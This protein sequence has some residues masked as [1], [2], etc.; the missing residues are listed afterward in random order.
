[1]ES[2]HCFHITVLN[3][4][5]HSLVK[6]DFGLTLCTCTHPSTPAH[7]LKLQQPATVMGLISRCKRVDVLLCAIK[8]QEQVLNTP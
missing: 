6:T 2:L 3:G 1:M 8:V 5:S 7:A 4:R